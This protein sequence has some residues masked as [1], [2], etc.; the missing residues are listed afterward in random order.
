[1][2]RSG[3]TVI[4]SF[5]LAYAKLGDV[6]LYKI[7]N[8]AASIVVSKRGTAVVETKIESLFTK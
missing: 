5:S 1:M 2:L 4:A 3:D 7:A 6:V 8:A